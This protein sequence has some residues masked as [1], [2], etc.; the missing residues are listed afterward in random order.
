MK[1]VRISHP[2]GPLKGSFHLSGSKSISN[3]VLILTALALEGKAATDFNNINDNISNLS[4]SVDTQTLL[5]LLRENKTGV[6]ELDAH[7]AGTT[8]RFLTA[9]LCL[10]PGVQILTGSD[11]MKKRPIGPL[12]E[13]LKEIGAEIDYAGQPG[14]PP[15]R[16]GGITG[17]KNNR[18]KL[19]SD[20]SSQFVSA[21]CMVAPLLE[22]GLTIELVGEVVSRPY[23]DMTLSLM[24]AYGVEV[25]NHKDTISIL[26]QV[27]TNRNYT[28]ES[29]WSSASYFFSLASIAPGSELQLTAYLGQALQGDSFMMQLGEFFGVESRLDGTTLKLHSGVQLER[30]LA[31]DFINQPDLAQTVAVMAAAQNRTIYYGGLQTLKIKE[32][33][34]VAA[35]ATELS[36]VG[37][38]LSE[39][40]GD[41]EAWTYK[42]AGQLIIDNPIFETYHD[43]RMALAFAPLGY[44]APIEIKNPKVVEKSYPEYW[45]DLETLGFRLE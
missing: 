35:L 5:K 24:K 2:G 14:Y 20:V 15:L 23:V 43:H 25:K 45:K 7:H 38:Q 3:R 27:Y 12:V 19:R 41:F 1:S 37:V 26:P 36:K 40:K 13:A 29:D 33:D 10:Q 44:L 6:E 42:Q 22:R 9:Y 28:V 32:T 34:R 17:E 21:L 31:F 11:R 18:I 39:I 16:I 8:F 4:S 30:D